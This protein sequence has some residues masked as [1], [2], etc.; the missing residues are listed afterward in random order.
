LS[1]RFY[2]V[3]SESVLGTHFEKPAGTAA[4]V[5]TQLLD[6][7][8]TQLAPENARALDVPADELHQ[9]ILL[10]L[11]P[12]MLG[13][14]AI[15]DHWREQRAT[16]FLARL[17]QHLTAGA[18]RPQWLADDFEIRVTA[19]YSAGPDARALA[20]T[21]LS[22]ESLRELA[23]ALMNQVLDRVWAQQQV[24]ARTPVP[25]EEK[26]APEPAVTSAEIVAVTPEP[27][28]I[29]ATEITPSQSRAVAI[30]RP[31]RPEAWKTRRNPVAGARGPARPFFINSL[32]RNPLE[33]R[34]E[35]RE[36]WSAMDSP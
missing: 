8:A 31:I 30:A 28:L 6:A 11:L 12:A 21:L 5:F 29:R 19:S 13:D 20:D 32:A 16:G 25:V 34:A 17:D 1:S 36:L 23:A 9:E 26:A 2:S 27:Q 35:A 7:S 10:P 4:E 33:Q 24:P 3:A 15:R 22:E 14:K 18:P